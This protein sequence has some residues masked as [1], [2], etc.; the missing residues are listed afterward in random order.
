MGGRPHRALFLSASCVNA[1]AYLR[2][3]AAWLGRVMTFLSA[4]SARARAFPNSSLAT[5][6]STSAASTH[7][8]ANRASL[9]F[10]FIVH[11]PQLQSD[12]GGPTGDMAEEEEA[13]LTTPREK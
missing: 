11:I 1:S 4:A 6:S 12:G 13:M 3:L 9:F 10:E 5:I 2:R 7:W 8:S